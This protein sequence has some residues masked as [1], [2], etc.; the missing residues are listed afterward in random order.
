MKIRTHLLAL[1]VALALPLSANA[2]IWSIN[3]PQSIESPD[4]VGTVTLNFSPLSSSAVSP[5]SSVSL[6]LSMTVAGFSGADA[7]AGYDA[8][9]RSL[10]STTGFFI[11]SRTTF[12]GSFPD[13]QT[14]DTLIDDGPG[15]ALD[16]DNNS[17]I[18]ASVNPF[19]SGAV[20]NGTY[21]L[22]TWVIGVNAGVAPGVYDFTTAFGGTGGIWTD[23]VA[24]E[25]TDLVAGTFSIT[26]IPEPAT[27]SL[28]GLGGLGA[29]GLNILRAR[30]RNI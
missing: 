17:D 27:W 6:T 7:V 9:L 3:E 10:D 1:A 12:A 18:G 11:Q 24:G 30:R 25:H 15:N 22:S 23:Q 29:I 20:G 13:P 19:P 28:L 4:V 26:V 14:A 16:P 21:T 2:G 5:G 8:F